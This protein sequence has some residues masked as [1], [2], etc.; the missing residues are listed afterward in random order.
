[1]SFWYQLVPVTANFTPILPKFHADNKDHIA[2]TMWLYFKIVDQLK[3][4]IVWLIFLHRLAEELRCDKLQGNLK[5]NEKIPKV[6]LPT[7]TQYSQAVVK[8]PAVTSEDQPIPYP[9]RFPF[10]I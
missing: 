2:E 3:V 1:M 6:N 5:R 8:Y 10:T 9:A 4:E 7:S